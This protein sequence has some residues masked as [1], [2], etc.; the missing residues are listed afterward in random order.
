MTELDH[1][2][3]IQDE[4]ASIKKHLRAIEKINTDA[5]RMPAA[6]A[7]HKVRGKVMVLHGEAME[8]LRE[9]W[10]DQVSGAISTRGGGDR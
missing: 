3:A 6:N 2:K 8:D 1:L 4:L 7:A 10:P 9:H 5:G